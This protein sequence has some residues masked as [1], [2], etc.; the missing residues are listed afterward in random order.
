MGYRTKSTL[1]KEER[2][3][4]SDRVAQRALRERKKDRIQF[5]ERTVERL[6]N[7]DT[8]GSV[9]ELTEEVERLRE[10][11]KSLRRLIDQLGGV[12][13]SLQQWCSSAG[14]ER[15]SSSESGTAIFAPSETEAETSLTEGMGFPRPSI[16]K[17]VVFTRNSAQFPQ[18][19]TRF[20][21]TSRATTKG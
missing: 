18:H 6:Q 4:N 21:L 15:G 17:H 9:R 19:G 1:T 11:K 16:D 10:E 5:L 13:S 12:T 2:K 14:G 20:L 8:D 7:Q 3:R